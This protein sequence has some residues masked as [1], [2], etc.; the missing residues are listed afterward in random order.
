MNNSI[1]KQNKWYALYTKPRHEKIAEAAIQLKGI[2]TYLPL[3]RVLRQWSD[4]KKWIEEPLF[5]GYVFVN[6]DNSECYKAIQ[7]RGV[8]CMVSFSGRP[9]IVRDEEIF[10]LRNILREKADVEQVPHIQPGELVEICRGPLTGLSGVLQEYRG[11]S[12]IVLTFPSIQQHV[13][14]CVDLGDVKKT[15]Q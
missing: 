4:R 14:F 2:E 3:N 8:M 1:N 15:G 10:L 13:R 7:S 5:K 6:G 9:A 11:T 12:K